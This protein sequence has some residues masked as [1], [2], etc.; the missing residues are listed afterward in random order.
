MFHYFKTRTLEPVKNPGTPQ[1]RF[2]I[3]CNN[4]KGKSVSH[5]KACGKCIYRFD[6][7]CPH[8]GQCIGAHNQ[9]SFF[10]FLFYLLVGTALFFLMAPTFWMDWLK[11]QLAFVGLPED[12]CWRP[13]CFNQYY[14]V[15]VVFNS[16]SPGYIL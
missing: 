8:M 2:C 9:A 11:T 10:L 3:Q 15:M 6:H 4:Y 7:H 14:W 13:Y 12:A 1:D 5:C 16:R